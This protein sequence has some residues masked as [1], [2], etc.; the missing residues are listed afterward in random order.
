[1]EKLI[2]DWAKSHDLETDWDIG[3]LWLDENQIKEIS[4]RKL[5]KF[6]QW[7]YTETTHAC[8]MVWA[9]REYCYQNDIEFS[10]WLML[11]VVKY[12]EKERWYVI[13]SGWNSSIGMSAVR[14]FFW[15][16]N[17]FVKIQYND[18]IIAKIYSNNNVLGITYKGNYDWNKD[19]DDWELVGKRF[20]PTTY[21]HRTSTQF[22][23]DQ[24]KI[25]I[26][27][28]YDWS[29]G[30]VYHI[31]HLLELVNWVNIYPTFYYWI[32]KVKK[33]DEVKEI[34]TI[35]QWYDK[36]IK[37]MMEQ[38]RILRVEKQNQER[39]SLLRQVGE[40]RRK[41]EVYIELLRN[42]QKT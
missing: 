30:N 32:P 10:V 29:K 39:K 22:D 37:E 15:D 34:F 1:M 7:K 13:G 23:I 40:I 8:T 16:E 9:V 28:S 6:N 14:K 19:S 20:E 25:F 42:T 38:Y 33:E 4:W 41:R 2:V 5:A 31:Q 24:K 3:A 18:P 17:N 12:A 21:W 35:I 11:D 36:I 26:N 27:D